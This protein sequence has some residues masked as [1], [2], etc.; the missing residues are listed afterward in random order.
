MA[1]ITLNVPDDKEQRFINAFATVFG[2]SNELGITK[3][4]FM[5]GKLK[6]Y[7]KEILYR[8]EIAGLQKIASQNLQTEID[9]IE[10]D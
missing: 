6:D 10:V 3:K 4:Q 7:A 8:A 5:K 2:W 1:Q 9:G